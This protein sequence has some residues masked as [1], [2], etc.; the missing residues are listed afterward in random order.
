MRWNFGIFLHL[1]AHAPVGSAPTPLIYPLINPK[2]SPLGALT[3]ENLCHHWA[4]RDL[5]KEAG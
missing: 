1:E 2:H 3:P 5:M 4:G